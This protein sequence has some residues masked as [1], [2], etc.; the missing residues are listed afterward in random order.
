MPFELGSAF[1]G[2]AEWVCGSSAVFGIL[3]NPVLTA[4]L[5]TAL[6]LIIIYAM[7]KDEIRQ[8][9]WR[10]GFKAG[11]WLL[12]GIS[13]LV[14][15]HYYALERSLKKNAASQGIRRVMDSIHHSA[16]VGGGYS[17]LGDVLDGAPDDADLSVN[18]VTSADADLPAVADKSAP[19]S[20]ARADN[21]TA[22]DL[23]IDAA[24]LDLKPA[25]LASAL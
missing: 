1:N 19:K 2:G 5:I 22:V 3:R 20:R 14:F 8:S 12:I 11:F 6:A 9:G 18:N 4:L 7:F 25:V 15:V 10:K 16:A 23:S 21:L 24:G 13:A 17:V